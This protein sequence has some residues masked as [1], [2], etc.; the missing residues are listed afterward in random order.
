MERGHGKY[1]GVVV[2]SSYICDT[3]PLD[4]T[5]RASSGGDKKSANQVGHSL[6]SESHLMVCGFLESGVF[7]INGLILRQT[8][9]LNFFVRK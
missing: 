6:F 1:V 7:M 8:C 3:R 4:D 2:N 9:I 5:I